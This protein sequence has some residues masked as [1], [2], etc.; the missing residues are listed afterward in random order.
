MGCWMPSAVDYYE[1]RDNDEERDLR[2]WEKKHG[3]FRNSFNNV[4]ISLFINN[5]CIENVE[6][7]KDVVTKNYSDA[8]NEILE[9]SYFRNSDS[10]IKSEELILLVCLTTVHVI[11]KS[12]V[13]HCDKASF[14]F[15]YIN[16]N[17]EVESNSPIEKTNLNLKN[18]LHKMLEISAVVLYHSYEKT[19]TNRREGAFTQVE[20]YKEYIVKRIIDDLYT[21]GEEKITHISFS[22]FN[23]LFLKNPNVSILYLFE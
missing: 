5:K 19:V 22:E 23:T 17:E 3:F 15:S 18:I 6:L 11:I 2:L 10:S 14:L 7:V 21:N 13:T 16:K 20:K 1:F 9:E 4:S 8:F 12:G